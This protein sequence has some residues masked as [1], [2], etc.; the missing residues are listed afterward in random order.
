MSRSRTEHGEGMGEEGVVR[1]HMPLSHHIHP[2][3]GTS[4][5]LLCRAPLNYSFP[6]SS[7]V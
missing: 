3:D 4:D 6:V 5:T 1:S 7:A 2:S